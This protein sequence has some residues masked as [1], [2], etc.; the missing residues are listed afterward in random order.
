MHDAISKWMAWC[1]DASCLYIRQERASGKNPERLCL[2]HLSSSSSSHLFSPPHCYWLRPFKMN[3]AAANTDSR[4]A[5]KTSPRTDRGSGLAP[6]PCPLPVTQIN[7]QEHTGELSP[8]L[9]DRRI[10]QS[11]CR[12]FLLLLILRV[13]S[14]SRRLILHSLYLGSFRG[15]TSLTVRCAGIPVE[16]SHT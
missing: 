9:P 14:R 13:Q 1:C 8:L 10:H 16:F 7:Q 4:G 6:P 12:A 11:H 5:D 3:Q 15:A 2:G